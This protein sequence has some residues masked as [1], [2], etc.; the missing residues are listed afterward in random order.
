VVIAE[1]APDSSSAPALARQPTWFETSTTRDAPGAYQVNPAHTATSGDDDDD[2]DEESLHGVH[3]MSDQ[4]P[5]P[6]QQNDMIDRSN[7]IGCDF[8]ARK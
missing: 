5:I 6:D 4:L 1:D 8:G 3:N 7:R 2:D